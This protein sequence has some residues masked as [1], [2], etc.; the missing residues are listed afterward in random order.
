[1]KPDVIGAEHEF[2]D[3]EFA[4][5]W[6]KRFVP[7]PQRLE[8]FGIILSEL[9][10]LIP[11]NGRILELGIGP[12]YLASHLLEAMP[13]VEYVGLDF[14]LPMLDIAR[15]RLHPYSSRITYKQANLVEDD[16]TVRVASPIN[17]IVSTWALHDLGSQTNVER[18]YAGCA[19]IL[20]DQ[21]ILLNGDFVKPVGATQ[22]FEPGR[23]SIH[24]HLELLMKA[25]FSAADCLRF[26]EEEIESPTPAQNYA[27]LKAMK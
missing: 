26:L 16:W 9:K 14:S 24:R 15:S 19:R 10:T 12:G 21:G 2:H 11:E 13:A 8:L 7:T 23:F 17:A 4:L 18:V 3:K 5:D 20:S 27:C 22:E 6:A 25:G 1:M